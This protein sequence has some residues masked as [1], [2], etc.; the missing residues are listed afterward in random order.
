VE[1]D[2]VR[3]VL[4]DDPVVTAAAVVPSGRSEDPAGIALDAYVV[5]GGSAAAGETE[6]V[7]AIRERA[8]RFLPEHMVP[9]SIT[10]VDAL[11]L[12]INGKLDVARLP[13]PVLRSLP[14]DVVEPQDGA[15]LTD[16]GT[17]HML[18]DIWESVLGV[19]VSLDDNLFEL[20]GN[21]LCA[22]KADGMMRRLGLPALPMR[23]LY[24]HPSIRGICG[25]LARLYPPRPDT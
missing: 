16:G 6:T 23:E 14:L 3:S 10:L 17:A 13:D 11:P 4:L 21:S 8:A 25:T 5:P 9:R 18:T 2:E 1:L 15:P 12:T 22:I 19:P 7:A 20:G 24:R